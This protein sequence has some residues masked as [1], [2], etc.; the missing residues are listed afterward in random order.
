[1]QAPTRKQVRQKSATSHPRARYHC[2]HPFRLFYLLLAAIMPQVVINYVQHFLTSS[3]QLLPLARDLRAVSFKLGDD[4]A[5]EM[6]FN[7]S[8]VQEMYMCAVNVLHDAAERVPIWRP[9]DP[10]P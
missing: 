9:D 10:Q 2:R 6:P 7:V 4:V 5:A 8:P 3:G 1:M